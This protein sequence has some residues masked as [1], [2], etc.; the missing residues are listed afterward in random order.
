MS[1]STCPELNPT[2]LEP[3]TAV[4]SN[5]ACF[6][7]SKGKQWKVYPFVLFFLQKLLWLYQ[8]E[9][10][11]G[12]DVNKFDLRVQQQDRMLPHWDW[13]SSVARRAFLMFWAFQ[14]GWW[15]LKGM[16]SKSEMVR[17]R[18]SPPPH[19]KTRAKRPTMEWSWWRTFASHWPPASQ[20]GAPP[21]RRGPLPRVTPCSTSV[22]K[23]CEWKR[24]VPLLTYN[25]APIAFC[26]LDTTN[27]RATGPE[28]W[29]IN[30]FTT[31]WMMSV[32]IPVMINVISTSTIGN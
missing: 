27:H 32:S 26:C 31:S 1:L 16:W 3:W 23:S 24:S 28:L 9:K 8:T 19:N 18:S 15:L 11:N 12:G 13:S 14:D 4:Y 30:Q 7:R 2:P 21:V 29:G 22:S 5:A 17:V 10:V 25:L 6:L 20:T